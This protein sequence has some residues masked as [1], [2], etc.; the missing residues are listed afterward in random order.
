[1]KFIMKKTI[2]LL[3]LLLSTVA[4]YAQDPN[5][6]WQRTIGGSGSDKL[7]SI[8]QTSDGGFFAGGN[9]DSNT[10]GEKNEDSRGGDDY[11]VLR[12]DSDG[13]I[14]WQRT[15]GGS[16]DDYLLS[17]Q[18][19]ID[20]GFI[21]GGNSNS[22]I[23]GD[24]NENSQGDLDYWIIKLDN[25]GNIQWQN[26]IGGNGI[27]TVNKIVETD[28]G[29]FV[30][31]GH[32]TS[33]ISGDRTVYKNGFR[34][35]WLVKLDITGD[36]LWQKSYGYADVA[37]TGFEKTIDGGFI[38]SSTIFGI[39]PIHDAFWALKIDSLGNQI[40]SKVIGGDKS[41]WFP[42]IN[43]TTDGGYIMAGA[44]DSDAF[45][46]KS[47]NSKGSFDYWVL[48]LDENGNIIW[49]NTIGGLEPE[50]SDSI[51]QC[52]DGGYVVCGYS[53]SNI[54]G[55]KTENSL[56]DSD[57]WFVKLNNVGIIEWQNT[58]GGEGREYG[59]RSLQTT[60]GDFVTFGSS[61]SNIS[62]DK[63]E[64]SRGGYDY[65][66]VKHDS[67]LDVQENTF[68]NA[69]FIYPNPV[70]NLLQINTQAQTIDKITIYSVLGSR[71]RQLDVNAISPTVDVSSLA[72]GVYYVQ[73]YSGKNVALKKFVKE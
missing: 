23:S 12:L 1:M 42:K 2:T 38:L 19:T 66:I 27:D 35:I 4:I 68:A 62:G 24:K 8:I 21:L 55:D 58:I 3:A 73:L 45:G 6:L 64:N 10:S 32:S 57:F 9:S 37:L 67:T 41:D 5:I 31:A 17:V 60:D 70:N 54:S 69:I 59:G 22:N 48:K 47:E 26:N 13:N 39:T 11:W 30:I 44:S 25:S 49:E 40:W 16:G 33:S 71:V 50:Q 34:D 51:I 7:W 52:E 56:G 28:E 46:D 63:T 36:I 15:F 53:S 29:N 43:P 20:E 14:L 72:S 65:W 18:Q 61:D